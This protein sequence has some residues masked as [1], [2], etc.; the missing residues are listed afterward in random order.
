MTE[1]LMSEQPRTLLHVFP[2][3][4]VG[5]T[6]VRFAQL[7]RHFSRAYRHLIV[8]MDG[9]TDALALLGDDVEARIIDLPLRK[10]QTWH[11][12]RVIRR[13]LRH[14]RPDLLVTS[15]WGSIEW[16]MANVTGI[17]RQLHMEDG[18][19][20]E[21]ATGQIPRR[22]WI[23]RLFLSRCTVLLPSE[24][25]FELARD[26]WKLPRLIHVPNGVDCERF[27]TVPDPV[28]ARAM[29]L[30]TNRP[31]IGT[32]AALRAEKNLGRLIDACA[33]LPVAAQLVIVG[34]GPERESLA[35][36]AAR[37]GIADRVLFTGPCATPEKLLPAFTLFALSSDT[38]QM[39][40][41]LIE[42][43]AAGLPVAAT[44][45]GDVRRMLAP[46]NAEFVVERDVGQLAGALAGLLADPARAAAIGR[47][48]ATRVRETFSQE[49]M[50]AAYRRLFDGG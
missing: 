6:Q 8:S 3:F 30:A 24:T 29:G 16:G 21:E 39:P 27:S 44:D 13:T 48:N 2:S 41:S 4:K 33:R 28:F 1:E 18:F 23:R 42:A 45:V 38:E 26:V 34:G 7:A 17:T 11:N 32:V 46:A 40:L 37:A 49:R 9:A 14:V 36:H 15:N 50:F 35:A 20:P 10:G 12:L 31:V 19:G 22:V 43:M 47:D 5:G 25:L